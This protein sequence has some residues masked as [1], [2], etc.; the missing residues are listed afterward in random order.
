[1]QLV[2]HWTAMLLSTAPPGGLKGS[3]GTQLILPSLLWEV[4]GWSWWL[5]ILS[6]RWWIFALY[7]VLMTDMVCAP[8]ALTDIDTLDP[9]HLHHTTLLWKCNQ[10]SFWHLPPFSPKAPTV[11]T[12]HFLILACFPGHEFNFSML[13]SLGFMFSEW[14]VVQQ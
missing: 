10:S 11:S 1:M 8:K 7:R 3:H 9:S 14:N 5:K 6:H 2:D 13:H 4:F 12:W